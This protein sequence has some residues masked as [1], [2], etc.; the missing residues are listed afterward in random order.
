M[1]NRIEDG[2]KP[3]AG[4]RLR[5]GLSAT[6]ITLLRTSGWFNKRSSV[7]ADLACP[8]QEWAAPGSLEAQLR[9][10]LT[11]FK[12]ERQ[13][14]TI[15][16]SD[17]LAR[18][19]TVTPPRNAARLSD[20]QAAAAAR[21]QMLYGEP[22]TGWELAASWNAR[23][24]FL[25][26]AIPRALLL[27]LQTV[28]REHRLTLLEIAPQFVAAYN[29]WRA[30]MRAGSWFAVLHDKVLTIGAID[31]Q[32]LRS[33]RAA[34]LPDQAWSDQGWL[35]QH[36][37]REALRLN[38]ALPSQLQVCGAVP[39]HW[40]LQAAGSVRCTRLDA[41]AGGA[42]VPAGVALARGAA[43]GSFR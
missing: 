7:L 37:S 8:E 34:P 29:F 24:P 2:M 27:T 3:G 43:P 11:E 4:G 1:R 10:M 20:C 16:L 31:Q 15:V 19:W 13:P 41:D 30:K 25:A 36:L 40:L 39:G 42:P 6:G 17:P 23:H 21:F 14:V 33:V 26:C 35:A 9:T 28:A 18:L 22:M 38:L 5:I 12:C 32:R